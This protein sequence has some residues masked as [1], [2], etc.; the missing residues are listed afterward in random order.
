M[1]AVQQVEQNQVTMEWVN[2][3]LVAHFISFSS[4]REVYMIMFYFLCN[5]HFKNN[6][7]VYGCQE[8]EL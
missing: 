4:L 5:S 6:G 3:D 2:V 8:Y 1:K 7:I